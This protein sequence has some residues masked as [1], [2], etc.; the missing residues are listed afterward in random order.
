[1]RRRIPFFANH[2]TNFAEICLLSCKFRYSIKMT[3]LRR[4]ITPFLQHT[5]QR[6]KSLLLLGARQTGKTTL[7]ETDLKP[8]LSYNLIQPQ[9]RRLFERKPEQLAQEI[10]AEISLHFSDRKPIVFI[11]EVQKVP[12]I[13]DVI[14]D[15]IDH[16]IAQFIL[17]GSS[18]RKFRQTT[19]LN[20]LPGR[21]VKAVLSP[22]M[23]T[24]LPLPLPLIDTL[25]I[26]GTLP[27][28]FLQSDRI[29]Q[30][31]DLESYV[32]IYLEEEIRK[33][34]LARNIGDFQ[35]F[36]AFAAMESGNELNINRVSQGIGVSRLTIAHYYQI[37]EDCLIAHRIEPLI[38]STGRQRLTKAPRFLMFDLG[39]RRICA[40]EGAALPQA[41]L[42]KLFEQFIGLELLR[43]SHLP[44]YYFNVHYW[45]D[46]NGPEIDFVL[47]AGDIY[48]PIEVKW[49]ESP[50]LKDC[51]HLLTFMNEYPVGQYGYI[52][53]Q[54][55]RKFLVTDRILALPWQELLLCL[56]SHH[57]DGACG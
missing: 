34:A 37:L 3:Y 39:V 41:I 22:L 29:D 40:N 28:I 56:P 36:L 9:V 54:T 52:I 15:L 50:S 7:V 12:A 49:T 26:Y 14:Q 11:D 53:C 4:A 35:K 18:A 1:M 48:V 51:R 38:K 42:G 27:N 16:N 45:R 47:D 55:P 10:Q 17:T 25:L 5:L 8:D 30:S 6:G 43:L 13:L 31:I 21:V 44:P 33:E 32:D 20:L 57:Q 24:E 2:V 19:D 46:H 23:L